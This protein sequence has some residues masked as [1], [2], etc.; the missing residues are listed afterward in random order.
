MNE[1]RRFLRGEIWNF[2]DNIK[3]G[4]SNQIHYVLIVES[5][6]SVWDST[7]LAIP[8]Y[9]HRTDNNDTE[10]FIGDNINNKCIYI[11]SYISP[12]LVFPANK[13]YM[14][15]RIC[16]INIK[17]MNYLS[18]KLQI[19]RYGNPMHRN[20]KVLPNWSR[21]KMYAFIRSYDRHG[22]RCTAEAFDVNPKD[23]RIY[24]NEFKRLVGKK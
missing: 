20:V 2:H 15:K 11:K 10:V 18:K 17:R 5:N 8:C 3:N 4:K 9:F 22:A 16:R 1:H 6:E 23:A 12:N 19:T 21:S 14:G 7:V 24:R 13:K